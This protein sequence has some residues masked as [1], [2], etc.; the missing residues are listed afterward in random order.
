[1]T[2]EPDYPPQPADD[3]VRRPPQ[4]G[5]ATAYDHTA[6]RSRDLRFD[7]DSN[8]DAPLWDGDEEPEPEPEPVVEPESEAA[9]EPVR[10]A[11]TAARHPAAD[12]AAPLVTAEKEPPARRRVDVRALAVLL[13]RL[14]A[15]VVA[16]WIAIAM[17]GAATIVDIPRYRAQPPHVR[18]T[19]V[20]AVQQLVCP[21]AFL[22]L[23]D[24]SG[25]DAS[26][27]SPIARPTARYVSTGG[28]AEAAPLTASEAG[29]GGGAD[30]PL[31]LS[32]V[33]DA[34]ADRTMLAGAQSQSVARGEARGFDA[35]ACSSAGVATW[36]VG[37]ASDLGRTTVISLTNPTEVAA[38]VDVEIFGEAGVV[39]APGT[40]G[41]I[42]PAGSQRLLPLA[43]FAPGVRSPAVHVTST[44]G[45]I[46]ASMQ[47]TTVRT[48]E[49]GGVDTIAAAASPST[50]TVIA[51]L[52]FTGVEKVQSRVGEEG[53]ADLATVLRILVPGETPT[54]ARVSLVPETAAHEG[55]SF[56]LQ[57]DAGR[58]TEIPLDEIENGNYSVVIDS[59]AP[60][61]AGVRISSAG[62][63]STDFAWLAA[64][65]PLI[66]QAL[67]TV[68]SGP[69]PL[70]HVY[71][72]TTEAARVT[73][74]RVDGDSVVIDVAAGAAA[75]M[76]AV[77]GASYVLSEFDRLV[78]SVSFSGDGTLG[79]YAVL[80]ASDAPPPVVVHL[81]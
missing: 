8:A 10:D 35:A 46:V 72:P 49:P 65:K 25:Q 12:L 6:P 31:V 71:N 4:E 76:P 69:S 67:V 74:A 33:V 11:A 15:G 23:A 60:V 62:T 42:V 13:A 32:T 78:G 20:P 43:A 58:V 63:L 50:T 3:G 18:V 68:A 34:S 70:L 51:G 57:L 79:A 73:V 17:V 52:R 48:L 1:M 19:P 38:T 54:A 77:P 28:E 81:R 45:Q 27:T 26:S 61:T 22:R 36:L 24:D 80:P 30:A 44:G 59:D 37:G 7:F 21:G 5:D 55:F 40:T 41:I 29:T 75:S 16:A 14:S 47:Q 66:D 2:D 64:G 39:E 9:P 53:Y 56:S